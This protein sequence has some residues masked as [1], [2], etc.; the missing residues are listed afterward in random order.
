MGRE[1]ARRLHRP[2]PDLGVPY[3]RLRRERPRGRLLRLLVPVRLGGAGPARRLPRPHPPGLAHPRIRGLLAVH[4]GGRGL[5]G[6]VRG[7]GAVAVGHGRQ[8]H[9]RHGGRRR[10]HR[11]RRP[12]GPAQRQRGGLQR[13]APR[14]DAGVSQ[15]APVRQAGR[16]RT[17]PGGPRAPS[18]WSGPDLRL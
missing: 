7:A 16:L 13:P 18:C 10:L 15:P 8:R 11:A 3:P 14:R 2:Q 9:R 4:D 17:P 12:P 1:G 6:P 5:R